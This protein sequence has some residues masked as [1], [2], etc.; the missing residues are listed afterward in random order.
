MACDIGGEC[1]VLIP[2]KHD[3]ALDIA[4][5]PLLLGLHDTGGNYNP[6]LAAAHENGVEFS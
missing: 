2:W 4:A 3:L 6:R 5:T 1:L